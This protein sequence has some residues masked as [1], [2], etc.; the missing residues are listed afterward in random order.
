MLP[1]IQFGTDG[2]WKTDKTLNQVKHWVN[3][4]IIEQAT[5]VDVKQNVLFNKYA[6]WQYL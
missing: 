3:K 1:E 2:Q 5:S 6:K 4:L